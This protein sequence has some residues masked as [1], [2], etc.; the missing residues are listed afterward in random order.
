MKRLCALLLMSLGTSVAYA[1]S[2]DKAFYL[3]AAAGGLE[4]VQGG[5]LAQE[6]GGSDAVK[7]MGAKV[8]ED[9][10]AANEKLASIAA[11]KHI[12]LPKTP[13]AK[14]RAMLKKLQTKSGAAFDAAY[15]KEEIAD[16]KATAALMQREATSGKDAEAKAFAAETLPVVKEHLSMLQ[17]MQSGSD[18]SG[19]TGANMPM[20]PSK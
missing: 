8:V 18:M 9:H 20:A 12:K 13:D 3:K 5:K 14:Q 7:S 19:H 16:H 17:K 4:E 6:K 11:S 10:T 15:I 1:G 2:P